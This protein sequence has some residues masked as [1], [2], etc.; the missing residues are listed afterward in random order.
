MTP[1]VPA[2]VRA[3]SRAGESR[4]QERALAAEVPVSVEINGIGYAVMMMTPQDLE[5][6]AVGF[7]LAD[8]LIDTQDDIEFIEPFPAE[9]GIILRIGIRKALASRLDGRVRSRTSD[10]SCGLC[11]IE[12]LEAAMRPLPE[13]PMPVIPEAQAVF[14][15]LDALKAHQPLSRDTGAVHGA[16]AVSAHGQV[17]LV[18]EDV[19]RHNAF[20]KLIGAMTR[21]GMLWEGGFALLTSRCSYELVEKAVLAQCPALATISLP[22]SLAVQRAKQAGLPLAVLARED[23][24]LAL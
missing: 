12:S 13:I 17:R 18:R 2:N 8:Q 21:T 1:I 24:Y 14:E 22:T 3:I 15:A 10:S 7:C 23:G 5:D 9:M 6:F 20:D 4:P 11:G 19:G 16:A